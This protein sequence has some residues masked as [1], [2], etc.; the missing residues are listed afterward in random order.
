MHLGRKSEGLWAGVFLMYLPGSSDTILHVSTC[1]K[2]PES[3]LSTNYIT[4][5]SSVPKSMCGEA[6]AFS[7]LHPLPPS[8]DSP[9]EV[10]EPVLPRMG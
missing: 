6:I 9:D 3:L 2:Q 4:W 5:C 8:L 1:S 7:E 10:C